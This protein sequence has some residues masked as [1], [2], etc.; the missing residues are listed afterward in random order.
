MAVNSAAIPL[1]TLTTVG[2]RS[3]ANEKAR[4]NL[5]TGAWIRRQLNGV[6]VRASTVLVQGDG[7]VSTNYELANRQTAF[8]KNRS[9][10]GCAFQQEFF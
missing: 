8:G 5:Y 6:G 1:D 4:S 9:S 2:L 7:V 3:A 10:N